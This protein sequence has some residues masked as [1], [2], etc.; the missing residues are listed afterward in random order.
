VRS[1][2]I[3]S[4]FRTVLIPKLSY[5]RMVHTSFFGYVGDVG[6]L[7]PS[8]IHLTSSEGLEVALLRQ[9][10]HLFRPPPGNQIHAKTVHADPD[11]IALAGAVRGRDVDFEIEQHRSV[12]AGGAMPRRGGTAF[13]PAT[14]PGSEKRPLKGKDTGAIIRTV[15]RIIFSRDSGLREESPGQPWE[16]QR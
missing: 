14:R 6:L 16:M 10:N 15:S 5:R 1:D 9:A 2:R 12:R 11:C 3:N 4:E 13:S 7:R 8:K